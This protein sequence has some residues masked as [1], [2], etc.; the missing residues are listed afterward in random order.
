MSPATMEGMCRKG[1]R[2]CDAKWGEASRERYNARR[3]V[4]R[5]SEKAQ[6]ARDAGNEEKASY[7]D[8]LAD[9]AQ[10]AATR[11]DAMIQAHEAE[12]IDSG[13]AGAVRDYRVGHTAPVEDGY[14]K[15]ITNL[16]DGFFGDDVY[17]HPDW[18][19]TADDET[20]DQLKAVRDNPDATVRIYRAVPHGH[21]EI[22]NGD[23]ITL[24]RDYAETHS[25]DL[26]AES[27][28]GTVVSM[29][30]PASQVFTDGNDLAEYGYNGPDSPLAS[31]NKSEPSD[32]GSGHPLAS[33]DAEP[34]DLDFIR[35]PQS[36]AGNQAANHDFGQDVEPAGRYMNQG[37]GFT[38]E[39]W[40]SG[41]V[42]FEKPLHMHWGETGLYTTEDNWKQRL[43]AHYGGKTGKALSRAV[44]D[45]G[46]DGIV[47]HNKYG[48]SEIVDL[49]HLSPRRSS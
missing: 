24:S 2:R 14:S 38:P 31:G 10:E 18:Y 1:G 39:G 26:E 4:T 12:Q 7:Y 16:T 13:G 11:Y 15:P 40:E 28:D 36:L 34:M 20:M 46:H 35:N 49:T 30:V 43:S 19:G 37:E 48:T 8:G 21:Q 27:E 33:Q 3:R 25:Y 41:S 42:R 47:T 45:D 29:D 17:D 9:S 44:R 6:A 32:G 5:N 22:N 23:W